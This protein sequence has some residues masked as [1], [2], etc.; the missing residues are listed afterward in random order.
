M[1]SFQGCVLKWLFVQHLRL[2]LKYSGEALLIR[3]K[4]RL[5]LLY[6]VTRHP[7]LKNR[8]KPNF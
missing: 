8:T 6:L 5:A 7:K 1:T 4:P 2:D 3:D